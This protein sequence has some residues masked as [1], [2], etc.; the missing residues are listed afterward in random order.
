MAIYRT[1]CSLMLSYLQ[2]LLLSDNLVEIKNV[3]QEDLLNGYNNQYLKKV[4][5][6][7]G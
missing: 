1:K 6:N 3:L 2:R 7:P 4:C 5:L